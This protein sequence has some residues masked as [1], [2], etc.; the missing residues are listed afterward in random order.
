MVKVVSK[1]S[2]SSRGNRSGPY[3]YSTQRTGKKTT[4]EYLGKDVV[5]MPRPEWR[6]AV[7]ITGVIFVLLITLLILSHNHRLTGRVSLDI[8]SSYTPGQVVGGQLHL[9]LLPGELIPANAIVRARLGNAERTIPLSQ[10]LDS[11][12]HSGQFYLDSHNLEGSGSGYGMP[13]VTRVYPE[14]S[15]ELMVVAEEEELPFSPQP[16]E[17]VA[18]ADEPLEIVVSDQPL[19][20]EP[21]TP[22]LSPPEE[23]SPVEEGPS[24]GPGPSEGGESPPSGGGGSSN[25]DSSSKSQDSGSSSNSVSSI[26]GAVISEGPFV[27][28]GTVTKDRDFSYSL[29]T[30]HTVRVVPGSVRVNGEEVPEGTIDLQFSSNL[31]VVS[32]SYSIEEEGFGADFVQDQPVVFDIPLEDFGLVAVADSDLSIAIEHEG[33]SLISAQK[34]ITTEDLPVVSEL[35]VENI[36]EIVPNE[37]LGVNV[38]VV[39]EQ[40]RLGVPVKWTKTVSLDN[41]AQLVLDIPADAEEVS[42]VSLDRSDAGSDMVI[43]VDV[44][45]TVQQTSSEEIAQPQDVASEPGAA[46]SE[47]I[48]FTPDR[49]AALTG[50]AIVDG[51]ELV[52]NGDV[53]TLIVDEAVT[54]AVVS[55]ETA[56]PYSLERTLSHGKEVVVV[57]PEAVHY[58]NVLAFSTLSEE[59]DIRTPDSVHVYW[60]EQDRTVE[61][62]LLDIDANGVYDYIEWVAPQLSSQT[63][64][65]EITQA[66]H[67]DESKAFISDIYDSVY[68]LDGI[69]SEPITDMQYVRVTFE[70]N[71]SSSND[72]TV[73]PRIVTGTPSIE[74]YEVNGSEVIATFSSLTEDEYNKVY[75]NALGER[76]QHTF[77]LKIV[78]GSVQFDHIIDPTLVAQPSG[79]V[80]LTAQACA[81]ANSEADLTFGSSCSGTYPAACGSS[82]RLS[83]DDNNVETT[84]FSSDEVNSYGGVQATVYNSTVTDCLSIDQ[85]YLCYERWGDSGAVSSGINYVTVD[86]DGGSSFTG[87]SGIAST[88]AVANPGVTCNNV[89]S[90]ESWTCSN[91]FGSSGTRSLARVYHY[92]NT[93][94][95]ISCGFSVDALFF[96]VTYTSANS[97]TDCTT[98]STSN[99]LYRIQNNISRTAESDCFTVS[100]SNITIDGQG[101][102]ISNGGAYV[103]F[104]ITPGNQNITI[105]NVSIVDYTYGV[106]ADAV[107]NSLISNVF[108]KGNSG[109]SNGIYLVDANANRVINSTIRDYTGASVPGINVES[110][111]STPTANRFED[112]SLINNSWGLAFTAANHNFVRNVTVSTNVSRGISITTSL[113][114]TIVDSSIYNLYKFANSHGIF[115]SASPNTTIYRT[116][117]ENVSATSATNTNGI[118]ITG[119]TSVGTNITNVTFGASVGT[120]ISFQVR[121]NTASLN[122]TII[123]DTPVNNYFFANAVGLR[124]IK[125]G[126]SQVVFTQQ[127]NGSGTNL[128]S[129][130]VLGNNSLYI[131]A[132][133][134]GAGLNRFANVTFYNL[135]TFNVP[136]I[137]KD[138]SACT[139]CYNFTSLNAGT[140]IFNVTDGGNYTIVSTG[141]A[142]T[143]PP[144]LTML[145]PTNTTY[146]S[147]QT[148]INYSV[149]SDAS[150]CWYST[151]NGATNVT[152]ASCANVT[153]LNSGQGSSTWRVYAN[154]SSGNVNTSRVSFTVDSVAPTID[155]VSPTETSGS[156]VART[157]VAVNVSASDS[158]LANITVRLYSSS[159]TLLYTNASASSPFFVNYTGLSQGTY[160]FN[161]SATDSTNNI[162]ST[163]TRSVII[164]TTVPL[165]S[166]ASGTAANNSVVSSN[167]IIANVSLTETN[168]AN[169]TFTLYNSSSLVNSTTF[170]G[171]QRAIN[172]TS[173]PQG[174]YRY[175]VSTRD[176]A[177]N[178]NATETRIIALDMG[179]P[180]FIAYTENP[181]SGS[182]Y[183]STAFYEL[184]TNA[185]DS[186]I[187]TVYIEWAGANYSTYG[188]YRFNRTGL[189]AGSYSYQWWANDTIGTLNGSGVRSY[190]VASRVPQGTLTTSSSWT[191]SYPTS[192]TIGLSESNAGDADVSYTVYRDGVSVSS[193]ETVTLGAGTYTY[194]LN[195]TSGQNYTSNASMNQQTLTVTQAAGAVTLYLNHSTSNI[196]ISQGSSIYLNATLT[197]GSG[198]ISLLLDGQTINSGTSSI[199]NVTSFSTP[200]T[201]NVTAVYGGNTN[202]S[203][204]SKTLFVYVIDSTP[205]Q[206]SFNQGTDPNNEFTSGLFVNVSLVESS[207]AN[208]TYLVFNS[209]G[210]V[211]ETT[212]TSSITNM[213]FSG[214][215]AGSYS[216]QVN[217]TDTGNNRNTTGLRNITVLSS[218]LTGCTEGTN[219]T[220]SSSCYLYSDLCT[221]SVCDFATLSIA[222]TGRIYALYNGSNDGNALILNVSNVSWMNGGKIILSGKNATARGGNGGSLNITVPGLFYRRN[223]TFIGRG[224]YSTD[225]GTAGGNGGIVYINYYGLVNTDYNTTASNVS[226]GTST[227]ASVGS[228]GSVSFVKSTA[229]PLDGDISNDGQVNLLGDVL[230]ILRTYN[231]ISSDSTYNSTYDLNCDSQI[232]ILDLARA[233]FA[234]GRGVGS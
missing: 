90:L 11:E 196:T 37:T 166:F 182:T 61:S 119:V 28:E 33:S 123:A 176:Q 213:S 229:C 167:S 10:I 1:K 181:A 76:T 159:M 2:N 72:I 206:I 74:V 91:F 62:T 193:G 35:I 118:H 66:Q 17:V 214:L 173:L 40:A 216:Y 150:S 177:N 57:G 221:G 48:D 107:N 92:D 64:I 103:G 73:Y 207:L 41:A 51:Q 102:T 217:V 15:F 189:A 109:G 169:V 179:A 96:N 146:S 122:G 161:A 170:T 131:N 81:A 154:D 136:A 143:T 203:A 78:G 140:V 224:G 106:Y 180:I 30:G 175:N 65:I 19:T 185:S 202:Y 85:V 27:V 225:S 141:V 234:F 29:E 135:P 171:S 56:A 232:N 144:N 145:Y 99:S 127:V 18:P 82:D 59:W 112:L 184:S 14:V 201:Y 71:L 34:D 190:T 200:G 12:S 39:Q 87:V 6:F 16:T 219:C 220:I 60:K 3:F 117:L 104:A 44:D 22:E 116:F 125:T 126:L 134:G 231:N 197:T 110:S 199:F 226:G 194:L 228:T 147:V 79:Q 151:D 223:A 115:I 172:W 124:M 156:Y 209:S 55:Y 105:K 158:N 139:T 42:I 43:Q 108:I 191:V 69:W 162:N 26:T 138:G 230:P 164:D 137:Y 113:N 218:C 47:P 4:T 95:C 45:G 86:A 142:D 101:Y 149:S 133:A 58:T 93:G 210:L 128:S 46:D 63:F 38:M 88:G 174:T 222:N 183:N 80:S 155:Y 7:V 52:D 165:I 192:V 233:G 97:I 208:I 132:T 49:D 160:Y 54:E 32:T 188:S 36:T 70:Q 83:C 211:N 111:V 50:N 178:G 84:T 5:V 129:T 152:I 163:A 148:A 120:G 157:S 31:V 204:D 130:V 67:L 114:T 89:T 13:G 20:A 21:E 75:L 227:S 168:F 205:P 8:D 195:A 68:T 212:S 77:D 215:P 9:S 153:G 23:A 198:S 98:L 187:G 94:L 186:N 24:S 100:A 25:E 121:V 53:Q